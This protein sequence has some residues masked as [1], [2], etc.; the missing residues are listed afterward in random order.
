M[1]WVCL[2]HREASCEQNRVKISSAT[3]D[4]TLCLFPSRPTPHPIQA[5]RDIVLTNYDAKA[6]A[7]VMGIAF[8]R[9]SKEGSSLA[10]TV[11]AAKGASKHL[12]GSRVSEFVIIVDDTAMLIVEC[13]TTTTMAPFDKSRTFS[14]FPSN[15]EDRP[16][17]SPTPGFI[18]KAVE[19]G[20]PREALRHVA[21]W[22]ADGDKAKAS[23]LEEAVVP[24]T[25]LERCDGQ[26]SPQESERTERIARLAVQACR[27]L[28]TAGEARAFMT[29]PHPELDGRRPIDAA[30]TDLATRRA[31]QLL[32]ALEY[33]LAL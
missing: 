17:S 16:V 19:K 22:L 8:L 21:E 20:L 26:L 33:G 27:A 30:K 15:F 4:I 31:E 3:A 25:T 13:K 23:I 1:E 11:E 28:G 32:N 5:K 6:I 9:S 2:G 18:E 7:E 29:T 12:S 24:R 14:G 10:P